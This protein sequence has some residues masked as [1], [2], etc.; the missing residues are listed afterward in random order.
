M[1]NFEERLQ[2]VERAL[3]IVPPGFICAGSQ[4]HPFAVRWES[5]GWWGWCPKCG[6]FSNSS[7]EWR[8]P[9]YK[10]VPK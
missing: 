10:G 9:D 2:A 4:T 8:H 6:A 5:N 7:P 1:N 3:H